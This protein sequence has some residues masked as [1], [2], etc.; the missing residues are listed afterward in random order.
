L[1]ATL[2]DPRSASESIATAVPATNGSR[3]TESGERL[4]VA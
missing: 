3:R 1:A 2:P 4:G